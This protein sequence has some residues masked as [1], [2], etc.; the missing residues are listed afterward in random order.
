[1]RRT[2]LAATALAALVLLSACASGLPRSPDDV[3]EY[4]CNGRPVS[5]AAFEERAPLSDSAQSA[6]AEAARVEGR[7]MDLSADAG[8]FTL[9]E[10]ARQVE[11]LR[12]LP[13]LR[14]LENGEI[15]SDHEYLAVARVD[16]DGSGRS[17]R[18]W[19][20]SPCVL[21]LDMGGFGL[22]TVELAAAPDPASRDLG[23]LVTEH[24]CNSGED[25]EGRIRVASL[26]ESSDRVEVMFAVQP[27]GSGAQN[28]QGIPGTPFTVSLAEPLGDREVV[29]I[30]LVSPRA[31]PT[32]AHP[33]P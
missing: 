12:A 23:F 8:W 14:D 11:V 18:S 19:S 13:E 7:E 26:E 33:G 1:M 20:S 28:C 29:D 6:L 17:W 2:P 32:A 30:G 3:T 22:A 4:D 15:P 10:S 16:M 27:A 24:A 5:R 21:R 25:A 9:T 31:V